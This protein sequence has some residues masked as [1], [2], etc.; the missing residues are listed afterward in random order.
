MLCQVHEEHGGDLHGPFWEQV[1]EVRTVTQVHSMQWLADHT[2]NYGITF[3]TGSHWRLW[4]EE[5]H[6]LIHLNRP[7]MAA[8]SRTCLAVQWLRLHTSIAG[9]SWG[10]KIWLPRVRHNL[11]TWQYCLSWA[12]MSLES[13]LITILCY[14]L[15]C[16][17]LLYHLTRLQL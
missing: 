6:N 14:I 10:I 2:I 1:D 16:L 12:P 11:A 3:G 17:L 5:W 8:V 7:T 9:S 4:A 13:T 15:I